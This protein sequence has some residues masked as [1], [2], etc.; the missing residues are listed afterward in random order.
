MEFKVGR[1]SPP[2]NNSEQR[3]CIIVHQNDYVA[4]VIPRLPPTRGRII[5]A[6]HHLEVNTTRS[7]SPE[8]YDLSQ[9]KTVD[10]FRVSAKVCGWL[11][12][13]SAT[14]LSFILRSLLAPQVPAAQSKYSGLIAFTKCDNSTDVNLYGKY[15]PWLMLEVWENKQAL[16]LPITSSDIENKR[17][18]LL[19]I[20]KVGPLTKP[21]SI[22]LDRWRSFPL[23]KFDFSANSYLPL[24]ATLLIQAM[25]LQHWNG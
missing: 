4:A 16:V 1:F 18:K 9:L 10:S 15:R 11:T 25:C 19:P 13:S 2:D 23:T 6:P 3:E 17:R 12:P 21:S 5:K 24:L 20:G 7:L 8:C 14:R 22:A